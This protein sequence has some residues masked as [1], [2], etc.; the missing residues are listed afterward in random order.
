MTELARNLEAPGSVADAWS[1]A[2]LNY[3]A[4]RGGNET[5]AWNMAM[6]RFNRRDL[7]GH[8]LWLRRA[9]RAGN[10]EAAMRLPRFE[11]RLDHQTAREIGRHRPEQAHDGYWSSARLA[12]RKAAMRRGV[13]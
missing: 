2:G 3:R 11:T 8:R 6:D 5:A 7:A 12:R 13:T 1:A 4:W 9:A 10:L